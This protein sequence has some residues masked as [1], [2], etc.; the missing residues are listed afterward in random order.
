M[1]KLG[2]KEMVS[3]AR[4]EVPNRSPEEVMELAGKGE[5]VLV[6]VREAHEL[7]RDGKIPGALHV[8]RGMLELHVDPNGPA[9]KE[10]F[11]EEKEIVFY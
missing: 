8:P 9:F 2:F 4:E 1:I 11:G 3:A 6:D 10:E 5:I 7:Q